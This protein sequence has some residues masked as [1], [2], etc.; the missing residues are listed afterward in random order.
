MARRFRI[1]LNYFFDNQ[2]N[3]GVVNYIY[4]IVCALKTLEDKE[5]PQ[6]VVFYS[7]NAPVDYLKGIGYPFI[8]FILFKPQPSAYFLR[9]ANS[10]FRRIFKIDAYKEV[11]FFSK[12]DCLYPYFEQID[13]H[14]AQAKN[15]IHWL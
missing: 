13:T 3:S 12:I 11:K 15:K 14:F 10:L 1:G 9:K 4:N 7:D 2:S 8:N 6:I 5:Q